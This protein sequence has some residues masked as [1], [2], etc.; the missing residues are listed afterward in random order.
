MTA[1]VPRRVERRPAI[2]A[3]HLDLR[4]DFWCACLLLVLS[5]RAADSG[6]LSERLR[7]VGQ[8][9]DPARV[10]HA[11]LALELGGLVRAVGDA[12][13]ARR[14]AKTYCVTGEGAAR[15]ALAGDE[16][17]G[18]LVIFGRFLARCAE[19]IDLPP[20]SLSSERAV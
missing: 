5:E 17:R 12:P 3:A 19:H 14:G 8:L 13:S 9:D 7:S 4:D 1:A 18:A 20:A 6:Q 10:S 16:L 2:D 15:L 11:L